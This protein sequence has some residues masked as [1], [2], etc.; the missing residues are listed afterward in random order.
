MVASAVAAYVSLNI[1]A[2]FTALLLGI[3]PLIA[4]TPAGQPL[5]SPFPLEITIPAMAFEHL[6]LFGFVEAII[7]A[8]VIRYFQKNEPA[9]LSSGK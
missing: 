3:Q 1:S 6:V 2:L 4:R 9:M 5:Y 7:T 8:L